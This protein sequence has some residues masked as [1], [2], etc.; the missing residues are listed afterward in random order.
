MFASICIHFPIMCMLWI[1]H[2]R[3]KY[4]FCFIIRAMYIVLRPVCMKYALWSARAEFHC[5]SMDR[6]VVL[7]DKS[8]PVWVPFLSKI[9]TMYTAAKTTWVWCSL[10]AACYTWALSCLNNFLRHVDMISSSSFMQ[11]SFLIDIPTIYAVTQT[12]IS[13]QLPYSSIPWTST[14]MEAIKLLPNRRR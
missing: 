2:R 11:A 1:D 10:R 4:H 12:I 6:Y 3:R 13:F 7:S 5:I 8:S 14:I 9:P